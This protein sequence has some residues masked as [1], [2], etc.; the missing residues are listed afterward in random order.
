[1]TEKQYKVACERIEELLKTV[2]NETSEN[3]KNFIELDFLSD[4]VADYEEKYFPVE[5]PNLQDVLKLRMYEMGISQVKL[6][7]ILNVSP[8]RVSEYLTGKSEPTLKVDRE[9]SK[10]LKIDASVVLGV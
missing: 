3:D 2:G 8:S 1:M 5:T 6:S 10:K 7:E 4:V 9:I